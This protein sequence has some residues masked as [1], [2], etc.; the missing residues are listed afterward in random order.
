M[1]GI[2]FLYGIIGITIYVMIA[3][4]VLR[5]MTLAH[6]GLLLKFN[7]HTSANDVV[8]EFRKCNEHIESVKYMDLTFAYFWPATIILYVAGTIIQTAF[9][10]L[11]IRE[12]IK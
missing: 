5:S 7:G 12:D 9:D 10:S 1:I 2:E 6:Y 11:I 4:I 8:T 3:K